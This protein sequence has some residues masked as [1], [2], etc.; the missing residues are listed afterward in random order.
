[1]NKKYLVLAGVVGVLAVHGLAGCG[2][3]EIVQSGQ[4]DS[5]AAAEA[6]ADGE[7]E[8]ITLNFPHWFFSHGEALSIM[9]AQS[10]NPD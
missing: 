8:Q 4:P 7:E 1:M 9:S 5:A 6:G 3:T 2:K 10:N